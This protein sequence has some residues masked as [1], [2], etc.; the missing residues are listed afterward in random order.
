M[1]AEIRKGGI[2]ITSSR[3]SVLTNLAYSKPERR[4]EKEEKKK[5][6]KKKKKRKK[7]RKKESKKERK[8]ERKRE[9]LVEM[10]EG[11]FISADSS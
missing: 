1:E 5:K 6:K 8:K 2:G 3:R 10:A 11:T 7:E 4:K 9:P